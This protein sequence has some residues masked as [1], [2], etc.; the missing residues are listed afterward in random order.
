M[1]KLFLCIILFWLSINLA[2]ALSESEQINAANFI[3]SKSY[4][5]DF[6][7]ATNEYRINDNISRKEVMK[8][9]MNIAKENWF[10]WEYKDLIDWN[11]CVWKFKDVINDWGCKYIEA[12]LSTKFI[13]SQDNFR[14][15]DNITVN[16]VLKLIFKAKK[17]EKKYNTWD[18]G[19]DYLDTA[20]D[21]WLILDDKT[22]WSLQA[23][24]WFI[25]L[26]IANS[27]DYFESF[28]E[29]KNNELFKENKTDFY[30]IDFNLKTINSNK[31]ELTW[32]NI[33]SDVNSI[34]ILSCKDNFLDT[35]DSNWYNLKSFKNWN[36][37]FKYIIDKNFNNYCPIPYKIKLNYVS[38]ESKTID[39]NLNLSFFRNFTDKRLW[40]SWYLDI[41]NINTL[42][43]IKDDKSLS[44]HNISTIDKYNLYLYHAWWPE[45]YA[46]YYKV[47]DYLSYKYVWDILVWDNWAY[48][49]YWKKLF[50]IDQKTFVE[51]WTWYY[52][53]KD[54]YYKEG[55]WKILY[56]IWKNDKKLDI[57]SSEVYNYDWKYY[58]YDK[59]FE[60]SDKD[61][62]KTINN[63]ETWIGYWLITY[64][65]FA[66][67]K[68]N[69]YFEGR[70]YWASYENKFKW[71][72]DT[73]K[74]IQSNSYEFMWIDK[75]SIFYPTDNW[76]LKQYFYNFDLDS[77]KYE[78]NNLFSDKNWFYYLNEE[79]WI[80]SFD[81]NSFKN[82]YNYVMQDK[83]K[84]FF[85]DDKININSNNFEIIEKSWPTILRITDKLYYIYWIYSGYNSI[86]DS[87]KKI[88]SLA[89]FLNWKSDNA[90]SWNILE[91]VDIS[92]F[93]K[94]WTWQYKDKNK[95]YDLVNEP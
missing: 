23:K 76:G 14:P 32:E 5:S 28:Q 9:I 51:F 90:W 92:T 43:A 31:Y 80:I 69:I 8:I 33:P 71:D 38:L 74:V 4:I 27:F 94:T 56:Q 54:N 26:V 37:S 17:I 62:F 35:Y 73:F 22:D 3:A 67:D 79:E 78:K 60:V 36:A 34:E 40:W 93:E 41:I 77:L 70:W 30:W 95:I 68:D 75:Y 47:K 65:I 64:I 1:K 13:E 10:S 45:N 63:T 7:G 18:W 12:A 44:S 85:L 16:E 72:Y 89:D 52:K 82:I 20:K 53:D 66:K 49:S 19:K 39:L 42:N 48:D 84:V 2:N 29:W 21:L 11:K 6:S 59:E 88:K 83:N 58:Y 15:D 91:N 57:L 50:S 55:N 81:K 86:Y 46:L 24:R 87:S 61:S 25:F